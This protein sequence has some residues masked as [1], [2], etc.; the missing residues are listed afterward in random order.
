MNDKELGLL[1][2][3]AN[4]LTQ[5]DI[6]LSLQSH[7]LRIIKKLFTWKEGGFRFE[8]NMLPPDDKIS[9]R[10]N[11]EN[12][13]L[14]GSRRMQ[15]WEQL[16]DEIPSLEMALRFVDRPSTNIRS[17]KLSSDEWKVISFINPKN[18]I[19]QIGRATNLS[20]LE[21]RRV[22][23]SL[24]QAG[25]VEFIR[26]EGM[27]PPQREQTRFTAPQASPAEQKSLINRIIQRIRSL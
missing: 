6:I 1:L 22:V 26:P 10:I 13:I 20:E 7:Y 19:Q 16:K 14:E 11:L 15:E 9:V 2:V 18:S 12:I 3:N 25:L 8:N 4:Y 23:Y 24:L 5:Q 27:K 17:L 21:I